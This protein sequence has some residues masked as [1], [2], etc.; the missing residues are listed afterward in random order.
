MSENKTFFWSPVRQSL[1]ERN[2]GDLALRAAISMSDFWQ[3]TPA[4]YREIKSHVTMK[5][6]YEV[7]I[8]STF[9]RRNHKCAMSQVDCRFRQTYS[10]KSLLHSTPLVTMHML[11]GVFRLWQCKTQHCARW[12]ICNVEMTKLQQPFSQTMG[13]QCWTSFE[14]RENVRQMEW[15]SD[16]DE[17]VEYHGDFSEPPIRWN[18]FY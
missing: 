5:C 17:S 7:M 16:S 1:A 10:D 2:M 11:S 12:Q 6:I 13:F 9:W 4:F 14:M 18:I 15:N 3:K 8:C